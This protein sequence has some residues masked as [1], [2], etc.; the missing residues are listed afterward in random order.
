MSRRPDHDKGDHDNEDVV[1]LPNHLFINLVD[2]ELR[3][4][5]RTNSA[6]DTV[7][8]DSLTLLQKRQPPV[9]GKKED[10]TE[11][12]GITLFRNK[13][14]VPLNEDLRRDIVS[15]Y[16]DPPVMGHPGIQKTYKLV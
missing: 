7:V 3:E 13:V 10:W 6:R 5:I 14:Y 11:D 1:L 15:R 8:T 16:H 12:D 4:R 9:I 2:L